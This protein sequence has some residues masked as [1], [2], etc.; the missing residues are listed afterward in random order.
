M[1][2][3]FSIALVGRPNVGKSTFFNKI[4]G[5]KLALIDDQPGV[6]RDRKEAI[7]NIGLYKFKVIDTP[8]LD[9]IKNNSNK[10]Q[11][12][13]N[14]QTEKA[15]EECDLVVFI[16]DGLAGITEDDKFLAKELRKSKNKCCL[17]IN[18]CENTKKVDFAYHDSFK[19]GLGE[20]ICISAEHK[21]G[22]ID[23]LEYIAPLIEKKEVAEE[24]E[25]EYSDFIQ[26][27]IIGRP[28]A[29]K[30]T[31]LNAMLNEQR[32]LVSE[33]AGTTRDSVAVNWS[34]GDYKIKLI[35]TAGLRRKSK[36]DDKIEKLSVDETK[37]VIIF[38]QV[39]VV[40]IDATCFL[41]KQDLSI[42]DYVIEEGRALVVIV[43]KWD[44]V[45][46]KAEVK[47]EIEYQVAKTLNN[48]HGVCIE[49][50]SALRA[51]NLDKLMHSVIETFKIWNKRISTAKLNQWLREIMQTNPVP[52]NSQKKRPKI[53]FIT[54][55]KARPPSF[56]LKCSYP[57]DIDSTYQ[58]FL[59]N[60]LRKT[61]KMTGVPI[62]M[63]LQKNDNPYA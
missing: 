54:Q 12:L 44:L 9:Y 21:L 32:A 45:K 20:P 3:E 34:Y 46:N 18:K 59:I 8:G 30:S 47:E 7:S 48:I 52:L 2:K 29:G 61:F 19:L 25:E 27:S 55:H 28:N 38:S 23:F 33:V 35:D 10:F 56:V 43:N 37:R 24:I 17:L 53:K 11:T 4:V 5:T 49:Y 22:F 58:K 62:R 36:V 14:A 57:E 39:V 50:I 51:E 40:L 1:D 60:S 41:E 42:I 13:M 26:L 63:L 15:I 31:L 16:I 6:T